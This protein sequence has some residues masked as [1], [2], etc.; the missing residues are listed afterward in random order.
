M[1]ESD[2]LLI[3]AFLFVALMGCSAFFSACEVAFFSLNPLQ[4]NELNDTRGKAGKLV[5]QLLENPRELL[6]TI[7]IGNELANVAISALAAS[8]AVALFGNLGI[9]IA[10]GTGTFLLLL[11]GEILP[12]TLSLRFAETY[13]LIAAYPLKGFANIVRPI[14]KLLVKIGDRLLVKMGLDMDNQEDATITDEELK[15]VL[16]DANLE[17][18]GVALAGVEPATYAKI[19]QNLGQNRGKIHL[20]G[21]IFESETAISVVFG[22]NAQKG[23]LGIFQKIF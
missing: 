19:D 8:I 4:L 22:A 10:V 2:S 21:R 15:M 14:Q 7:Y 11:F 6:V 17:V 1:D 16:S 3:R 12:K 20:F 13:S 5:H 18:L 23:G 9:G